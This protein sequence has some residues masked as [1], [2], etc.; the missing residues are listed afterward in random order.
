FVPVQFLNYLNKNSIVD[1]QLGDQVQKDMAILFSDIRSFTELSE[2]LT[3]KEN[4]NFLNS[5]LQRMSPVIQKNNGF[6]D[7]YIGDAIMALFPGEI[8]DAIHA[9]IDMQKE[10][11][12][13]NQQRLKIGY[14]PIKIG[15]GIHSG[16]LMLGIIGA[17]ARM[18]G[19]V[20]AD[21]VNVASR[22]EGL[23]KVYDASILVSDIILKKINNPSDYNYRFIDRVKVKGKSDYTVIYEIYDGQPN[24]MIEL[25]TQ[26]KKFFEDAITFYYDKKFRESII[27][28]EK[29]IEINPNDT[30]TLIYLK[31]AKY[32]LENEITEFLE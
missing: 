16:N 10:I 5:Y 1:I 21:S 9:A 14:D 30:A 15:C 24:F 13:Y 2:K 29:V 27:A 18:E 11:R 19:T 6:I 23:T 31:R 12:V 17:D 28:F 8:E 22:I 32:Y 3:P 20:I 26:T 25:K 7:K 4:F